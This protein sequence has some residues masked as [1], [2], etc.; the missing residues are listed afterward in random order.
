MDLSCFQRLFQQCHLPAR[1]SR[2]DANLF[3]RGSLVQPIQP[4]LKA[5]FLRPFVRNS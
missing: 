2:Q 4:S 3:L 1:R 5:R